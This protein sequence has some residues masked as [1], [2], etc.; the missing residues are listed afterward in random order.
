MSNLEPVESRKQTLEIMK[1]MLTVTEAAKVLGLSDV[2]VRQLCQQ[3][4]LGTKAGPRAY[5]I[6]K[7]EL[8]EFRRVERPTG[9][10][11]WIAKRAEMSPSKRKAKERLAARRK[12]EKARRKEGK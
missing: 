10:P 5:L 3:G 8:E 1:D 4:R 6:S 11:E 9:N 12:R 7:A 2:R